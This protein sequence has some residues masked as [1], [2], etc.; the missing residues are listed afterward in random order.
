MKKSERIVCAA[1]ALSI[2]SSASVSASPP[3]VLTDEAVYVNLDYYGKT[4]EVS[5]VK[6]CSL[7]GNRSIIDYGSYKKVTNMSNY[8]APE[9]TEDGVKWTL[10]EDASERFYYECTPK[11][12]NITLPWDFDVT[13]LLNGVQKKAEDLAGASGL[14]E[15]KIKA[16]PNEKAEQYYRQNMLLQ[17]AMMVDMEDTNSIE[18][19]GAQLQSM[20]T[21]KAVIFMGLPGEENEFVF[22]IGTDSF[23]T[24]GIVMMMIP[25]TLEQLKDIKD[26]KEA[27]DIVKDSADAVYESLN[28]I[29][30]ILQTMSDGIE[31][32]QQGIS[33]LDAARQIISEQKEETYGKVDKSL[34]DMGTLIE[35][36]SKLTPHLQNGQEL[37]GEINS[38]VN[39]LVSVLAGLKVDLGAYSE[40]VAALKQDAE[41]FRDLLAELD[42]YKGDRSQLVHRLQDDLDDLRTRLKTLKTDMEALNNSTGALGSSSNSL[43]RMMQQ[44]GGMAGAIYPGLAGPM[45]AVG[46]SSASLLRDLTD[47]MNDTSDLFQTLSKISG[48]SRDMV[49]DLQDALDLFNRYCEA[50]ENHYDT[51][52]DLLHQLSLTAETVQNS[53]ESGALLIDRT[54]VLND[55]FNRYEEGTVGLLKDMETLTD[56]LAVGLSSTVDALGSLKTML[57]TAGEDA[58][59][60]SEQMMD[61]LID[62]LGKSL[63]GIDSTKRITHAN[64]VIKKE[65]DHQ[66]DKFEEENKLLF[67]D[68]ELPLPSFTSAKNPSPE[69]IQIILRT[70]EISLDDKEDTTAD[71]EPAKEDIGILARIAAVFQNIWNAITGIFK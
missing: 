47:V 40:S 28:E 67:L 10:P 45:T 11:E 17:V 34:A 68:A 15:I 39:D 49:D 44:L 61:G 36:I 37:V 26:L 18:A 24:T 43:S 12:Q 70:E 19:P 27:K 59:S 33:G 30:G 16:V 53:I 65:L 55:T 63:S 56:A 35:E 5:I 3:S 7:N 54:I 38:Q 4:D 21:Y 71:L 62:I 22:R 52:D 20:G 51:A 50:L 6:S 32:T 23:E 25:G 48:E 1:L 42:G 64:D 29:L 60:G 9:L 13:Y 66:L 46:N 41:E 58:N 31:R 2:M 57:Q 14:V 69:S 8:S